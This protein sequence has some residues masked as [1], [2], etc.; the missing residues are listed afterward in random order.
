MIGVPSRFENSL[1]NAFLSE[2]ITHTLTIVPQDNGS[3]KLANTFDI[4][5]SFKDLPRVG[6]RWLLPK[7]FDSVEYLGMGP[8]ENYID[9]CASAVYGKFAMAISELPGSYL[10]PQSAGNRTGVESLCI[11]Q[12]ELAFEVKGSKTFEFSILPYSDS[13]LFEAKHWHELPE[14]NFQYLYTDLKHRGVGTRSCGPQLNR[15]Y[16]IQPG[17]YEIIWTTN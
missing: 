14:Q 11:K 12:K 5:D 16:R 9:R 1:L 8:H 6:L 10:L 17:K 3:I 15:R 4:P 7:A 13:E 2:N